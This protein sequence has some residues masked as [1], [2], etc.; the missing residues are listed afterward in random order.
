MVTR[1]IDEAFAR[2]ENSRR[3]KLTNAL[4]ATAF[5]GILALAVA[6]Y[7]ALRSDIR[8]IDAKIQNV[9]VNLQGQ[10]TALDTSLREEIARVET[11]RRTEMQEFRSEVFS[12]LLDHTDRLARLEEGLTNLGQRVTGIEEGLR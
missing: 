1:I 5:A 11:S 12:V 8:S 3:A 10:I 4:L 7:T 9:E 2:R 6:G